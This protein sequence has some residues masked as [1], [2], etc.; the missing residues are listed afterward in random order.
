[1]LPALKKD[2]YALF[3]YLSAPFSFGNG[4]EVLKRKNPGGGRDYSWDIN[5]NI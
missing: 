2:L 4:G 5:K 1:M 3:P